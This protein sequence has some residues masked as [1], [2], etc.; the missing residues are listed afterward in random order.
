ELNS[1]SSIY[2]ELDTKCEVLAKGMAD[3]FTRK[4]TAYTINRLGSMISIHFC[5]NAVTDFQSATAGNNDTFKKFFHHMLDK[6]IYLPPSPFE[7]W[8]LCS[9]LSNEDIQA[10][11]KACESFG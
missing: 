8:F 9:V 3:V 2:N 1:S 6:G 5:P 4:K 7:S 10:T 11:I